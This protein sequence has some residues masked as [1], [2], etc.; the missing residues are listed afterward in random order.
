MTMTISEA[1]GRARSWAVAP[2]VR[3]DPE[4]ARKVASL[5]VEHIDALTKIGTAETQHSYAGLCPDQADGALVRDTDCPACKI[6]LA[7]EAMQA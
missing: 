6:L 2:G 5:L 4:T 3:P 7:A 1:L